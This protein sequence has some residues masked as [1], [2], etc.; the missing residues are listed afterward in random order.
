M[1]WCICPL[2]LS[3]DETERLGG[4]D[5]L[6]EAA[7]LWR[8]FKNTYRRCLQ[9][10]VYSNYKII[11]AGKTYATAVEETSRFKIFVNNYNFVKQH[12]AKYTAGQ[13][14][15]KVHINGMAD[16]VGFQNNCYSK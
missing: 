12:N 13:A 4:A 1:F 7:S 9:I 8:E 16:L 11:F 2:G 3:A 14:S 5:L 10:L 6:R 15:H